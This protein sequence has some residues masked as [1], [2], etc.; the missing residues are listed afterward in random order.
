MFNVFYT[1]SKHS[2]P[3]GLSMGRAGS[4]LDLAQT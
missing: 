2:Q 4:V 3:L 1:L